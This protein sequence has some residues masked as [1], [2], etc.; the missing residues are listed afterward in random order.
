MRYRRELD[1]RRFAQAA[2]EQSNLVQLITGMQEIKLNN[3]ET[4][5]RW[6]WERI[7]IKLFRISIKGL[8]LG[9]YQQVRSVFFNQTTNIF[10]SFQAAYAVITGS[11]TLGM[12][13]A[14]T[15]I[16]GQLSAPIEQFIGFSRSFQDAKISLERLGE[17]HNKRD[18]EQDLSLKRT[19]LPPDRAIHLEQLSFSY[20]G[21]DRNYVLQDITLDILEKKVTAIVGASGSGKTTLIKLML[22]FYLP[23]KG[24][25]RIGDT[26]LQDINHH[27]W[28]GST[29]SVMQDGFI[30]FRY[31]SEEC[32]GRSRRD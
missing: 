31:Y 15:Y 7:Q 32:S 2:G 12:M 22:G 18:E 29:G 8:A 23:N 4:E 9:Q 16:V 1:I 14:L 20:D 30:F 17:I 11:M 26:L 27:V 19:T 24:C 28:R 5:K 25:I 3:C 10:I 6:Q 21:A 13:T